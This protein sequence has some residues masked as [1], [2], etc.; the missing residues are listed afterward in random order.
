MVAQLTLATL[1]GGRLTET[2]V[3]PMTLGGLRAL[4]VVF[5]VGYALAAAMLLLLHRHALARADALALT[6]EERVRTAAIC[7]RWAAVV[8]IA[9]TS[10]ILALVMPMGGDAPRVFYLTPG[11]V[12]LLLFVAFSMLR[13]RERNLLGAAR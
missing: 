6:R 13:R 1:S 5:G 9:L 4:Y 11:F 3:A 12:Y 7:G 8:A 10:A 2:P